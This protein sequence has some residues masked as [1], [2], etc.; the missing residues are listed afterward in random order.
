MKEN[1]ELF[2][3]KKQ[4][5]RKQNMKTFWFKKTYYATYIFF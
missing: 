2:L 1:T 5:G 4:N 3:K